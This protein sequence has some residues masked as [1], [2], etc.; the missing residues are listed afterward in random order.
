MLKTLT[1]ALAA[2]AIAVPVYTAPA[3]ATDYWDWNVGTGNPTTR[4]KKARIRYAK[5]YKKE[6]PT[7]V[8]AYVKREG[9]DKI[10][11]KFTCADKVRGL[12]TQ[13]IGT[14]GAMDAAKKDWMERVR[15]DYGEAFLDLTNAQDFVSRCGRT[16]IGETMGQVMYR[17][18]ILAR[19]C[20]GVMNE[21]KATGK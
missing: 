18:E 5:R 7:K 15:Y 16:S 6:D 12:G 1:L 11:G 21:A 2:A 10:A 8:M 17:C 14:E 4:A 13:W 9:E 20:K 19:P 3:V